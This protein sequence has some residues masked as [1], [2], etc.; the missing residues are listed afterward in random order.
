MASASDIQTSHRVTDAWVD[1]ALLI[2]HF[3]DAGR[4]QR[5]IRDLL[6]Q[7]FQP[8]TGAQRRDQTDSASIHPLLLQPAQ[9]D[10]DALPITDLVCE[11]DHPR[12]GFDRRRNAAETEACFRKNTAGSLPQFK[13]NRK[14]GN[15]QKRDP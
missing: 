10:E 3:I 1:E 14:C 15:R 2:N 4:M 11:E 6:A 8:G 13:S 5:E 7:P 12:V 9:L